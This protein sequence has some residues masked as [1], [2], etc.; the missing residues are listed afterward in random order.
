MPDAVAEVIERI[1]KSARHA[2]DASAVEPVAGEMRYV[3]IDRTDAPDAGPVVTFCEIDEDGYENRKVEI[4][5][6]GELDYAGGLVE[7]ESTWLSDDP[8]G[9]VAEISRRAGFAAHEITSAEFRAAW[10]AAGGF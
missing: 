10:T 7:G 2:V 9:T 3:R 6:T 4:F 8:V 1:T 5:P